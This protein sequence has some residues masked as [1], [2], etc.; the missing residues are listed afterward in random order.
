MSYSQFDGI[1]EDISEELF[2]DEDVI[3][4]RYR[5]YDKVKS[6]QFEEG[7]FQIDSSAFEGCISLESI[8]LPST[9]MS[10]GHFVFRGCS[11]LKELKLPERI[12]WVSSE[13]C[14][15]CTSLQKAELPKSLKYIYEK[16]FENCVSL[17]HIQFPESIKEIHY[18]AFKNCSS[19]KSIELPSCLKKLKY[20]TF[21][22][23]SSLEKIV[24]RDNIK[25]KRIEENTF[26]NCLALK[27]CALPRSIESIGNHSFFKCAKLKSLEIHQGITAIGDF[28][29]A[30]CTSIEHIVL[31]SSTDYLGAGAFCDCKSL[32]TVTILNPNIEIG[33]EAFAGCAALETVNGLSSSEFDVKNYIEEDIFSGCKSL[34]TPLG[35][36]IHLAAEG[37]CWP[38]YYFPQDSHLWI[39]HK[40]DQLNKISQSGEHASF[41][42]DYNGNT[43]FECAVRGGAPDEYLRILAS[44]TNKDGKTHLDLF[45]ERY[46]RSQ[47]GDFTEEEL[48]FLKAQNSKLLAATPVGQGKHYLDSLE[49]LLGSYNFDPRDVPE[50]IEN[51]NATFETRRFAGLLILDILMP[52]MRVVAYSIISDSTFLNHREKAGLGWFVLM[53]I[54]TFSLFCRESLQIRAGGFL[55]W[56]TDFWN[57]IDVFV[58]C[59][60]LYTTVWMHMAHTS[61]AHEE[62]FE[63]VKRHVLVTTFMVWIYAVLKTRVVSIQFAIFVS[64]LINIIYKLVPFLVV[65]FL[66][67]GA[68]AQMYLIDNPTQYLTFQDAFWYTYSEFLAFTGFEEPTVRQKV[69]TG[70]F[71][72]LIVIL[73]LNVV[74][75]VVSSAWEGVKERGRDDFLLYRIRLF[76]EVK[77]LFTMKKIHTS[78]PCKKLNTKCNLTPDKNYAALWKNSHKFSIVLFFRIILNAIYIGL[79]VFFAV[80]LPRP[81]CKKIFSIDNSEGISNKCNE[82]QSLLL[83][84]ELELQRLEKIDKDIEL[85]PSHEYYHLVNC[86]NASSHAELKKRIRVVEKKIQKR[87]KDVK[88]FVDWESSIST[89]MN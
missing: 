51:L 88:N 22:N 10:I 64:G 39:K 20:S 24:F 56:L 36:E 23:C 86:D 73:L 40:L 49:L 82:L 3:E 72:F 14:A 28:A 32:Q 13:L 79:S 21:E 58:M 59:M 66:M 31:P 63:I 35:N 8:N 45:A 46:A 38:E 57:W 15:D 75:A 47:V 62:D 48:A 68:F 34:E 53:Y 41:L 61:E 55:V 2:I 80:T 77:V 5:N 42:K 6:A 43:A 85:N 17:K 89:K 81:L 74:I 52:I 33:R 50:F 25:I 67:L 16:A 26:Y 54:T 65:S 27:E 19:L 18:G 30:G 37:K 9:L 70:V 69:I 4:G 71:G 44:G 60:A 87:Q 76:L 7:V 12:K 29:F 1:V 83:E 78:S 84:A 11:S